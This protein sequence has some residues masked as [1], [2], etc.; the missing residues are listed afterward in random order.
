MSL[1]QGKLLDATKCGI[2][3]KMLP[4]GLFFEDISSFINEGANKATMSHIPQ[5]SYQKK[6]LP[7]SF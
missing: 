7:E 5:G 2:K 6:M 4:F 3:S 1:C